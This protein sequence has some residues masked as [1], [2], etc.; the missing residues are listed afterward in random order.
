MSVYSLL[1][2]LAAP[3]PVED[4]R[5]LL[6]F[7]SSTRLSR[8]LK[9]DLNSSACS[10]WTGVTCNHEQSRIIA[11]RLPAIGFKGELRPNTL[12]RLSALEILCLRSN[13]ISGPF[14]RDLL[15]LPHLTDLHLQYNNFHGPLPSNFT[16]WKNLSVLDLSNNAFNGNIPS[17]ISNLTH[18]MS[19]NFANNSLSGYIPDLCMPSL[20]VLNLSNNNLTGLVP[21]SLSKFPRSAF[22]GNNNISF[23]ILPLLNPSSTANHKKHSSKFKEPLILGIAIGGFLIVFISVALLLFVVNR[24]NNKRDDTM[25]NTSQKK[26]NSVRSM[27]SEY[28]GV[29]GKITFFEGCN[30]AF[31]LEDLLRASAEVLGKGSFG[32]T[33]KAALED[34]T[35]VVVKRLK[36]VVVGKREFEHHMEIIGS[37][38]HEN[39]VPLRAYYYSKDEKLVVYDYYHW[40]SVSALLHGKRGENG[41]PLD[42]EARLKIATGA[43]RGLAH[44]HSR[45]HGKLEIRCFNRAPAQA[46][47]PN[48][49]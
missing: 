28:Q 32:T 34:A 36:E 13:G 47:T 6:E 4:K 14:P 43:A 30:L 12:S 11:V 20:Q 26:E 23:P 35:T 38:R 25:S 2:S 41:S 44:I 39:V 3:E 8:N 24:K 29:N 27:A 19:L 31:D 16:V 22:S 21:Q 15:K 10:N 42:W 18:L 7:I 9:W 33:Y 1:C 40:G 46:R 17:S 37:V 48:A 49:A 45:C 5:V